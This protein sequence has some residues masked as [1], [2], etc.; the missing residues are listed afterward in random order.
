MQ[1]VGDVSAVQ[2]SDRM[3]QRDIVSWNSIIA[4]YALNGCDLE[5]ADEAREMVRSG[6]KP[7]A[8]TVVSVLTMSF[9]D[10]EIVREMHGY[11]LRGVSSDDSKCARKFLWEA[12][13]NE[14]RL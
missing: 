12:C 1:S 8:A 4:A 6:L 3:P 5:A 14:G 2:V 11:V 9:I 10:E 7:D 13:S